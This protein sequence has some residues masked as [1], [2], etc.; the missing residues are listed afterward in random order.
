[1][2]YAVFHVKMPHI[3]DC[4][5]SANVYKAENIQI[6]LNR[7]SVDSIHAVTI[8]EF[9]QGLADWILKLWAPVTQLQ[10]LHKGVTQVAV[11]PR[12]TQAM[13]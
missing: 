5:I 9:K 4:T 3:G 1:M 8:L 11:T 12:H 10:I 2:E 6:L 13:L 7:N